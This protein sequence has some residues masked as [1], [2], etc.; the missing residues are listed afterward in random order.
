ML[1]GGHHNMSQA[2][3]RERKGVVVNEQPEY[4]LCV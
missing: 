4:G 2:R 3:G 1:L